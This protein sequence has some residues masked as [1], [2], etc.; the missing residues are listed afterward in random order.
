M[1][2]SLAQA[3]GI[4]HRNIASIVGHIKIIVIVHGTCGYPMCQFVIQVL[5]SYCSTLF[6]GTRDDCGNAAAVFRGVV[7]NI[8]SLSG[9]GLSEK[10]F[11]MAGA[12]SAAT[13]RRCVTRRR[14]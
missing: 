8:W 3:L 7:G 9:Q 14:T 6:L 11:G 13:W 4:R 2:F 12:A 10:Y 5:R 1:S